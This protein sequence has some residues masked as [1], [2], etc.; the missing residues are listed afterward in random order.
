MVKN[1]VPKKVLQKM[2]PQRLSAVSSETCCHLSVE[3][4]QF[5]F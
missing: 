4:L 2:P 5:K 1:V 3:I